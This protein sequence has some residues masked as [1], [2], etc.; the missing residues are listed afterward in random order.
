MHIM[1]ISDS[2][3]QPSLSHYLKKKK[4]FERRVRRLEISEIISLWSRRSNDRVIQNQSHRSA[5]DQVSWRRFA[6]RV[7]RAF[8]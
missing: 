7:I 3:F 6:S 2:A 8:L 5:V 4:H 1:V